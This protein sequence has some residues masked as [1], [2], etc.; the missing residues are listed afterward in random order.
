LFT[1]SPSREK[2]IGKFCFPRS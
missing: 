2:H 1:I